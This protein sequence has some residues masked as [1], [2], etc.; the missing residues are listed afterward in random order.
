MRGL[1]K[2]PVT[3]P[4]PCG[5]PIIPHYEM[6]LT[7]NGQ[8]YLSQVGQKNLYN[9]IQD[10]KDECDVK[11][12][13]RRAKMGDPSALMKL[14]NTNAKYG[15]MT[16]QPKNL[17]EAHQMITDAKKAFY[18]LP[19]EVREKFGN[20]PIKFMADEKKVNEVLTNYMKEKGII[21]KEQKVETKGETT[22]TPE[23]DK[24]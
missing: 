7:K 6:R 9:I 15:D 23:G 2:N 12:I 14:Q 4:S 22:T 20:D 16:L 5:N 19:T 11:Q 24:L 17:I 1:E 8:K 3:K 10:H 13:I 18:E 21:T